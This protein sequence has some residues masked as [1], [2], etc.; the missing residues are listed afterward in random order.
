[1]LSTNSKL[2]ECLPAIN[3]GDCAMDGGVGCTTFVRARPSHTG[4]AD[5]I[6]DFT[7]C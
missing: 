6:T 3:G 4:F 5:S 1:M 2:K 7:G